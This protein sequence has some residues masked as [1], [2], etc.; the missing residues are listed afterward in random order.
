MCV[1][2]ITYKHKQYLLSL[3]KFIVFYNAKGSYRHYVLCTVAPC[4][5]NH[6]QCYT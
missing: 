2:S 3:L 4:W 5:A 1:V 6:K